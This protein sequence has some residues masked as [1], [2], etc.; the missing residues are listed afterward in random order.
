[1]RAG[2]FGGSFDPVHLGHLLLAQ[3]CLETLG[4]DRLFFVPAGIP[5]H[6]RGKRISSGE[7]RAAMLEL[8]VGGFEEFE[9]SRFE[10]DRDQT[11]YTLHTLRHFGE[12]LP[13]AELFLVVGADMFHDLPNWYQAKEILQRAIPSASHRPGSGTLDFSLF[14]PLVSKDRLEKIRDAVVEMPQ[15][16]LSSSDIRDRVAR[17][18]TIRFQVPRA[19]EKYIEN[20]RLYR[21]SPSPRTKG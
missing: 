9:V 19:V 1:M 6:K 5:P 21:V 8:A 14:E 20:Q 13:E 17:G 15:I 12:N 16:D 4:L 10:I 7:D 3:Q 11:S 2:I 18:K